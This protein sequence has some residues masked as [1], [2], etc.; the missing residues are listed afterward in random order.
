MDGE[1]AIRVML[2]D[3]Q[4]ILLEGLETLISLRSNIQIVATAQSGE[5]ALERLRE[6]VP[7]VVLMDIR[8]PGMGGVK[9]TEAILE[10][11]PHVIVLILTTFDD[12]AYI[13]EALSNGASGYLLK[14]IDGEKLVQAIYEA[15]S[16]NLLLTGKVANKLALNIR[17]QNN[18]FDRLGEELE[19]SPRE[20]DLARL[21]VEGHNAKEMAEK[22]FL[23]QGTVKNYLSDIYAKLGTNDRAKA[24]LILK[25]HLSARGES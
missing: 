7:D 8:M 12:D 15:L 14:D 17:K 11:Y 2:V 13:I 23:T 20:L 10:R 3:D 1:A 5:E 9:A 25:R 6:V 19:F 18:R 4:K 21:L 16:G 24:T 22:L